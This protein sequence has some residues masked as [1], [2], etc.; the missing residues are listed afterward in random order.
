LLTASLVDE[1]FPVLPDS[2]LFDNLNDVLLV[3]EKYEEAA[4]I[5]E[6]E[7]V[8]EIK[9]DDSFADKIKSFFSRLAGNED[10]NIR[11]ESVN[12]DVAPDN[13][14]L[15]EH[16]EPVMITEELIKEKK[17][18]YT[19]DEVLAD[20]TRDLF[21]AEAI[22]EAV[23]KDAFRQIGDSVPYYSNM[24]FMFRDSTLKL[25]YDTVYVE[26]FDSSKVIPQM[27]YDVMCNTFIDTVTITNDLIYSSVLEFKRFYPDE[28]DLYVDMVRV[29]GGTFKIG[30]N[31]YDD[32]ERPAYNIRVSSFLISKYEATNFMFAIFLN[33]LR[34]DENGEFE[35]LKIIDL[36]HPLT[37]I[38][39][40]PAI[41]RFEVEEGYG[42]YPVVN[43]SWIGAQMFCKAA[44]G[45][46]PSEAE[47]E[48]A[49]RGGRYARKRLL[50]SELDDF[51]YQQRYAGADYVYHIGWFVDNS[52]GQL[53]P[54]G[55][56]FPNE[57]GI[58]DMS[59]NV[60]EWCYDKYS[61][62]FYRSNNR[63]NDPMN[64]TGPNIRAVRGGSWS[65]DAVFC[66]VTN[67]S[68][69][70]QLMYNEYLGFRLM[71]PWK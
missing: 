27:A 32:D 21:E 41:G 28:V 11:D 31:E 37:R 22:I 26:I 14:A 25:V 44:G 9:E 1:L 64:V 69:L 51:E 15:I 45:R 8:I 36:N 58:H 52:N 7:P 46:L 56:K 63:S 65:N 34:C 19:A 2:L 60:W 20:S 49:A 12:E 62:T 68:R 24:A 47:W 30:S 17:D 6:A 33:D 50:G 71:L 53:W 23:F 54:V 59:G 29:A 10:N 42:E 13:G 43:V 18:F 67:R 38:K 4:E 35:G 5:I 57:L 66:R 48:Y 16:V 61:S 3:P 39:Y 70:D 55:R 40:L